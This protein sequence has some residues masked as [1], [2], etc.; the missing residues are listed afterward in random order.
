MGESLEA[1][2]A[3]ATPKIIP[4]REETPKARTTEEIVTWAGK[5]GLMAKVPKYPSS[6]P[7]VPPIQ[8][9]ITAS[10]KN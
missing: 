9:K 5:N 2:R 1:L 7:V 4:T 3:G 6:I 8:D 10:I